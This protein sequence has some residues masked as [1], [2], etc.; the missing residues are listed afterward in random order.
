MRARSELRRHPRATIALALAVDLGAGATLTAVAGARR[1]ESAVDR[2]VAFEHPARGT[3]DAIDPTDS[4]PEILDQVARLPQVA[5][6]GRRAFVLLGGSLGLNAVAAVDNPSFS[7]PI[8]VSGRLADPANATEISI[9]PSAAADA[10]L[11]VGATLSGQGLAPQDAMQALR[12][13]SNLTPAGPVFPLRVVGIVRFPTDLNVTPSPPG[14]TFA[15]GG[16]LYLTP[17][18]FASYGGKIAHLAVSL[19]YRLKPGSELEAFTR[20][21]DQLSAGRFAVHPGSDDLTSA[22]QAGHAT[23]FEALA[24]L[25]FGILAGILTGAMIAQALTRQG[26]QAAVE[27]PVLRAVGLTRSQ[28]TAISAVVAAVIGG[29]GGS[30]AAILAIA[31]SPFMPIGLAR[32][33]E[34][35]PGYS[36]DGPVLVGGGLAGLLLMTGWAAI[37]AW[38]SAAS[39]SAIPGSTASRRD[40]PSGVAERIG[41]AG[42]PPSTVVGVRMALESGRGRSA[43]PVHTMLLGAVVGV[44]AVVASLSFGANLTRLASQP[45]LQGWNWDVSVGNPHADDTSA[46]SIPMLAGNPA[47]AGFSPIAGPQGIGAGVDGRDVGVF[48]IQTIKGSVLPPFISGHV[49]QGP[50]EIAL[51]PKTLRRLHR[52]VGQTVTLVFVPTG[53]TRTMT[54]TGEMVLTPAVVN[55]AMPLGEGALVAFDALSA[56]PPAEAPPVNVLAVV[57]VALGALVLANIAAAIP[58]LVAA[59]TPTAL[60]LRAE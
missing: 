19:E 58:G 43:V 23:R 16:F 21:V 7:R 54:I 42:L 37:T 56:L 10:H 17:A 15:A 24:L 11:R 55:D 60:L 1:A 33:A 20:Q 30:L 3:V 46:Q 18:F 41:R 28:F 4:A 5:A 51:A 22:Q 29:L 57:L 39:A 13:A 35:H 50:S 53:P 48:G 27:Y 9:N 31:T 36:V 12:G 52:V 2:F 34:I 38:R 40:R 25:L 44:A 8:V 26:H 6:T 49:P 14:V 59:R 32:Q 47:V 45:R